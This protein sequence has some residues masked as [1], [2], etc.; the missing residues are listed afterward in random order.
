MQELAAIIA[1]HQAHLD[2]MAHKQLLTTPSISAHHK[3]LT[4]DPKQKIFRLLQS[5]DNFHSTIHVNPEKYFE[6][7]FNRIELIEQKREEALSIAQ[8]L[9]Q[10]EEKDQKTFLNHVVIPALKE[11]PM[12]AEKL[13]DKASERYLIGGVLS[14][15]YLATH[16]SQKDKEDIKHKVLE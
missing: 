8:K 1:P 13:L 5:R 2:L 11:D 14:A 15:E 9:S 16:L 3:L 4:Y 7:V 10:I 12:G 6:E